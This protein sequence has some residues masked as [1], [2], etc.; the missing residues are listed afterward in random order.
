MGARELLEEIKSLDY[1]IKILTERIIELEAML[2]PGIE[3]EKIGSVPRNS[4]H[5][6]TRV[7]IIYKLSDT[8]ED[9]I[10]RRAELYAIKSQLTKAISKMENKAHIEII[11]RRY[12]HNQ[13]WEKISKEMGYAISWCYKLHEQAIVELDKILQEDSKR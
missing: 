3:Y 12:Y 1:K 8:K 5:P 9:L 10:L 13:R 7:N 6:D 4:Y 11:V 2:Q